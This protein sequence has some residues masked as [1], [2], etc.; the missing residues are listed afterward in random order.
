LKKKKDRQEEKEKEREE[1]DPHG[2]LPSLRGHFKF[3]ASR[4][5]SDKGNQ[6]GNLC[7]YG[8]RVDRSGANGLK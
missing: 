6:V 7:G 4:G 3:Y 2:R 8:S 5:L 1:V